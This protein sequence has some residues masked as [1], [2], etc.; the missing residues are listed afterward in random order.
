MFF[1]FTII[2]YV[3]V[4]YIRYIRI[5]WLSKDTVGEGK[6]I[7]SVGFNIIQSIFPLEANTC[8]RH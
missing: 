6:S 4:C 2:T 5:I 3:T 1:Y 8:H 7:L